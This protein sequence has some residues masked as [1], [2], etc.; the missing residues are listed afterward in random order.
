MIEPESLRRYFGPD[1][2]GDQNENGVDLSL[3]RENL[4]LMPLQRLRKADAARR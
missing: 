1:D 2:Y 4:K 3:I